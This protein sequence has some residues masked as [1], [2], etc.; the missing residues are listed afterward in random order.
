M[1]TAKLSLS[2]KAGQ[3][4]MPVVVTIVVEVVLVV[5]DCE[6]V[7]AGVVLPTLVADLV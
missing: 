6:L 7:G 3:P 5:E 2:E 1:S 4:F